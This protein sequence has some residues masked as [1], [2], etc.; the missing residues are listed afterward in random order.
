MDLS[1]AIT[2]VDEFLHNAIK[3]SGTS[4][5]ENIVATL[6]QE[7]TGQE[8]RLSSSGRQSGRD[9]ASESGYANHVKIETKHYLETTTLKPRELI[10]EIH[11]AAKSDPQLDLWVLAASK[12]VSEQIEGNLEAEAESYGIDVVVLDLGTNGLPRLLVLMA[13]F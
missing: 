5:F 6:I 7:A 4:G 13:A 10:A 8:F 3:P 9:A 1:V 12:A 2:R 11:E